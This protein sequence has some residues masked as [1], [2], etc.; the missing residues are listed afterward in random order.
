MIT[1]D[2]FKGNALACGGWSTFTCDIMNTEVLN[3][4]SEWKQTHDFP[5]EYSDP[6]LEYGCIG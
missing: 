5:C 6:R 4:N 3:E 2:P 1:S